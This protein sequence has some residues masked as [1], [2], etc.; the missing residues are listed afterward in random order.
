M[1]NLT[2]IIRMPDSASNVQIDL[3]GGQRRRP[4]VETSMG[5]RI[6]P[7]FFQRPGASGEAAGA[8]K[9]AREHRDM[10]L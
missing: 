8:G 4:F 9:E 5:R 10:Q 2:S 7:G 6:F 3:V 1:L